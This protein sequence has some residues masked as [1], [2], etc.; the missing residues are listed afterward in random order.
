LEETLCS[1]QPLSKPHPPILIGGGGEKQTLRL[2]AKHADA[3]NLFARM[4]VDTVRAKLDILKQ[5]CE[6]EGRDY[7]EIE[8]TT[9]STV[10]L[11]PD[12]MNAVNVI[13]ECKSLAAIGVQHAIFNMPN[14]HE[15][16]PLEIFGQEI[17]PALAD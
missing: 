15:I 10:Y 13:E 12:K 11:A 17:I 1:P 14:V 16:K 8:K 2:V 4:G 3:C 9:L 5:H 6:K 7:N